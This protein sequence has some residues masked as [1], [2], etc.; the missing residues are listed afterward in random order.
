[1]G[2]AVGKTRA[3]ERSY[4][5][6]K[7]FSQDLDELQ[8]KRRELDEQIH[9][10][11]TMTERQKLS[12]LQDEVA[13]DRQKVKELEARAYEV[14][15]RNKPLIKNHLDEAERLRLESFDISADAWEVQTR[16]KTKQTE[17]FRLQKVVERVVCQ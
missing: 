13:K 9:L 1:M 2:S 11:A 4:E 5:I 17:V 12:N 14:A 16:L 6:M 10:A 8:E 15:I 3:K 7:D